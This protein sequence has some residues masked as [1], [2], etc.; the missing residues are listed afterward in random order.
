LLA[1]LSFF[2][3]L[4]TVQAQRVTFTSKDVF[5]IPAVD[6]TIRFSVTGSYASANLEND[7]WIFTDLLLNGSRVSGTL[8]FSAKN[9]NV[10]IH[11]FT[12]SIRSSGGGDGSTVVRGSGSIRYTADDVGEQVVNIG[13]DP[14]SPSHPS[15]WSVIDQDSVFFSEGRTWKLLPDDTLVICGV[16]GTLRVVRYNFGSLVDDRA[17]YLR[18]SVAIST[19]IIVAL[20]VT[21]ATIIK[22]KTTKKRLPS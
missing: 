14:S 4:G 1:G 7:T 9:C 3:L 22:L 20:T 11:S 13:F 18:H 21:F 17:F 5:D 6:G 15:E 8:K 10:V 2:S 16:S 12:P 19:A